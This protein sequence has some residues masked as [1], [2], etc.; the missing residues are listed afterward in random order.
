MKSKIVD[1][2]RK[3]LIYGRK[4]SMT[5]IPFFVLFWSFVSTGNCQSISVIEVYP[6][7]ITPQT[8]K[9]ENDFLFIKYRNAGYQDIQLKIFDITGGLVREIDTTNP[10]L[11]IGGF[12]LKWDGTDSNNGFVESGIYIYQLIGSKKVINGTVCVAR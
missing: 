9:S 3:I 1:R 6:K 12:L 11:I 8:S 5:V 10:E 4:V 2:Y 7:I